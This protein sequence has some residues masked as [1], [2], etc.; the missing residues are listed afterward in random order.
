MDGSGKSTVADNIRQRLEAEGR[1]V[2]VI[3]HP[4]RSTRTGHIGHTLLQKEGKP[5][6]VMAIGFYIADVV[7]SLTIMK[8]GTY[9]DYIFVR[10]SMAVAYLPDKLCNLAY[11]VIKRVLPTPDVKIL[12][13][14]DPEI[15]M[16][17]I[18]VRGEDLE[19]FETVEKLAKTRRRMLGIDDGWVPLDNNGN[20]DCTVSEIDRVLEGF[21]S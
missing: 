2:L 19:V 3:E 4:S 18:S 8:R 10:Y 17:R 5:A 7:R 1:N 16:G 11:E 12:V 14:V 9:D 13:D 6:L 21:L 20:I 15:A